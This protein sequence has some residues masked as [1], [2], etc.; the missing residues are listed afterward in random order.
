MDNEME[1]LE[2]EPTLNNHTKTKLSLSFEWGS[3]C[4]SQH[5]YYFSRYNK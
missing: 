1:N 3:H 4:E 5:Q 2:E